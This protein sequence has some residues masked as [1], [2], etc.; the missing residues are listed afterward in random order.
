MRAQK[1][2]H[3]KPRP[4]RGAEAAPH[5][6]PAVRLPVGYVHKPLG[7]A[8]LCRPPERGICRF[9]HGKHPDVVF[10]AGHSGY[11]G[12]GEDIR[13]SGDH[14]PAASASR[15]RYS[16][17]SQLIYPFPDRR[18]AYSVC[19]GDLLTGDILSLPRKKHIGK[20]LVFHRFHPVFPY[21]LLYYTRILRRCQPG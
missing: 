5:S 14:V 10:P 7:S 6:A 21:L 4:G 20:F 19:R 13:P 12:A 18:A 2:A 15:N 9:K 3:I 17:L 8:V 16:A 11:P 1:D